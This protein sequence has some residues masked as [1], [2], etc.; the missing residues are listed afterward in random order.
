MKGNIESYRKR[1]RELSSGFFKSRVH[2]WIGSGEIKQIACHLL[3][4]SP[5]SFPTS[6][7]SGFA[8]QKVRIKDDLFQTLQL[9]QIIHG[10]RTNNAA[11]ATLF[12]HRDH[13]VDR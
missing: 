8:F 3:F 9:A 12:D 13:A 10:P 11:S 2:I 5:F 4:S 6:H 7:G 1:S